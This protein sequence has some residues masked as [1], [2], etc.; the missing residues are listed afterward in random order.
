MKA[1][2]QMH[3]EDSEDIQQVADLLVAVQH[4][5]EATLSGIQD[6][7]EAWAEST[8]ATVDAYQANIDELTSSINGFAAQ[9]EA[10]QVEASDLQEAI[11][12]S[13]SAI[14]TAQAAQ[15]DEVARRTDKHTA[16]TNSANA[17]QGAIDA[18]QDALRLLQEI[19]DQDLEGSF[20]EINQKKISKHFAAIHES[21]SQLSFK[22]SVVTMTQMLVE[23]A[24]QGVNHDLIAQIEDLIN[25]LIDTL[26]DELD[27][28]VQE[29]NADAA[30]SANALETLQDTIDTESASASNNQDTLDGVND[31]ISN[32][33]DAISNLSDTLALNK[34]ALSA[35]VEDYKSRSANYDAL[36]RRL[37]GDLQA[38]AAAEQFVG[39]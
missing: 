30:Y 12:N 7:Y 19:D 15:D 31:D 39:V 14:S 17:I 36:I 25:H 3:D 23:I 27:S 20:L 16:F 4:E 8:Q 21:L 11:D 35:T 22:S 34:D 1:F 5:I 2:V 24:S 37:Q 29:D 26:G 10:A 38:I 18:A 32:Y 9:L 28:Y 6:T 13:L 33:Q